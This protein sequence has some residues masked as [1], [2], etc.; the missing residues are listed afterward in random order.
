MIPLDIYPSSHSSPLEQIV[1]EIILK[2]WGQMGKG[3]LPLL[4]NIIWRW[5]REVREKSIGDSGKLQRGP[6][7]IK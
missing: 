6:V 4:I 7:P 3:K 5:N 1:W 2:N